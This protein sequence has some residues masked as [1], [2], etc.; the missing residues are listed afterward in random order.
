MPPCPQ[1]VTKINSA[2]YFEQEKAER[3]ANKPVDPWSFPAMRRQTEEPITSN[4][5][6]SDVSATQAQRK[7]HAMDK[8]AEGVKKKLDLSNLDD[9]REYERNQKKLQRAR[10]TP[11]QRE[12]RLQ[13]AREYKATY[14]R[15]STP[16]E[17]A[18]TRERVAAIRANWTDEQIAK[19]REAT[20]KRMAD[21]RN[22]RRAE[23]ENTADA[24]K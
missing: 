9:L 19:N 8:R 11:E 21:L 16:K 18:A 3:E 13:K 5:H 20:R 24:E 22:R 23:A 1:A 4:E 7:Q 6:L 15:K 10:E 14:Q 12:L 2:K 17:K